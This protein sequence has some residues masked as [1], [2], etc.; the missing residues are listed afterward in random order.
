MYFGG[1]IIKASDCNYQSS[2]ELG[3]VCPFCSSA[4]FLRSQSTREV[5]GKIQL[6]R[7]YFAHYPTGNPDNWDCDNRSHTKQGREE[8]EQIKIQARN[9][10]LKLYN[11]HLWEMFAESHG[12]TH[13]Q[14]NKVRS[15]FGERWCETTSVLV[16]HEWR[17]CLDSVYTYIDAVIQD[18]LIG[19]KSAQIKEHY[20]LDCDI[21][22]HQVICNEV[23]DFLSTDSSGYVFHKL[24]KFSIFKGM[25]VDKINF[26][27]KNWKKL[28]PLG[29]IVAMTIFVATTRWTELLNKRMNHEP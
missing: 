14:L 26:P 18:N 12:I 23:A 7:P 17:L 27:D 5:K 8:I 13:A 10:R 4:V 22:F 20:L 6:V 11:A 19:I 2:R 21:K 3:I 29:F 28:A 16:R 9:Q 24:F 25:E 1:E 15:V